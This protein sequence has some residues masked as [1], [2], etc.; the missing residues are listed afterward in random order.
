MT[1]I[2]P[3]SPAPPKGLTRGNIAPLRLSIATTDGADPPANDTSPARLPFQP[4]S[5]KAYEC[6]KQ[7]DA[8]LLGFRLLRPNE[9]GFM[10]FYSDLISSEISNTVIHL[11]TPRRDFILRGANL[12]NPDFFKA[13][14]RGQIERITQWDHSRV[15]VTDGRMCIRE[16]ERVE[17]HAKEG[18]TETPLEAGEDDVDIGV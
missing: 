18:D 13:L 1:I 7:E 4:R 11:E 17:K 15:P 8:P 10:I 6:C 12:D 9:N 16:I 2:K 14:H 5:Y 3:P